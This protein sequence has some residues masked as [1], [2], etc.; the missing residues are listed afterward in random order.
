MSAPGSLSFTSPANAQAATVCYFSCCSDDG[1]ATK[2]CTV[3]VVGG[4]AAVPLT[5]HTFY[6]LGEALFKS[7]F[8]LST[9]CGVHATGTGGPVSACRYCEKRVCADPYWGPIYKGLL[10]RPELVTD[11][12]PRELTAAD[13][14]GFLTQS[15]LDGD[16]RLHISAHSQ[17]LPSY[18]QVDFIEWSTQEMHLRQLKA[19]LQRILLSMSAD[20]DGYRATQAA[21]QT[22]NTCESAARERAYHLRLTEY[23]DGL[24][25]EDTEWW[26]QNYAR[27]RLQNAHIREY[28]RTTHVPFTEQDFLAQVEVLHKLFKH[29]TARQQSSSGKGKKRP[30]CNTCNNR[31]NGACDPALANAGGGGNSGGNNGG[32]GRGRGR[33]Q[34]GRGNGRGRGNNRS[35]GGH[36]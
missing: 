24:G 28:G 8:R 12:A 23:T 3:C 36:H 34:R 19:E 7:D 33:Q 20:S 11:T 14:P 18:S 9:R 22:A 31:H 29:H 5:S 30:L 21:S 4:Q 15:A 10:D 35:H 25:S 27:W 13:I 1:D 17:A 26:K 2:S 6:V 16:N 32:N